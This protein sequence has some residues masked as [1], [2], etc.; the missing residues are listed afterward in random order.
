MDEGQHLHVEDYPQTL[1]L[2]AGMV[3]SRTTR[4]VWATTPL[5]STQV[6]IL[7]I[8]RGCA[9]LERAGG[10]PPRL[11]AVVTEVVRAVA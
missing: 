8:A 6:A 2:V 3:G 5:S 9:D 1:R 11:A 10:V 4:N 7:P